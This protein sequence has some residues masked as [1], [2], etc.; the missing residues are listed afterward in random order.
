MM[1]FQKIMVAYD[2][3]PRSEKALQWA[4]QLALQL[5]SEMEIITVV[6]P[7]EFSTNI[8]EI[9]EFYSDGDSHYI[10][11]LEESKIQ[12]EN[13]GIL[14]VSYKILHGH[15]AESIV[16]YASN[17]KFDLIVMGTRGMGGFKNLIIGSVAQRVMT[18]AEVPVT[19]IK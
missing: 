14:N 4:I 3:S 11:A 17:G 18:Y 6:T 9:D 13:A 5:K 8:D 10:P 1:M 19:I 15:P 7:P 16:R 2:A 12:A